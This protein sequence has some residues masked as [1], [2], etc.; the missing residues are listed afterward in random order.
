MCCKSHFFWRRL[1]RWYL[2]GVGQA[3]GWNVMSSRAMSPM[4]SAPRIPSKITYNHKTDKDKVRNISNKYLQNYGVHVHGTSYPSTRQR[5]T[6]SSSDRTRCM[7]LLFGRRV[8][9]VYARGLNT[10]QHRQAHWRFWPT[11]WEMGWKCGKKLLK[12]MYFWQ[13]DVFQFCQIFI[14]FFD[15]ASRR[16][17]HVRI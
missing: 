5:T 17:K 8:E 11:H 1:P 13:V 3:P 4:K 14:H 12:I 9:T 16:R 7:K 2:R 15:L 10:I 6:C